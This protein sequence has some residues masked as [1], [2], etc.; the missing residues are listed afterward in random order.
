[1]WTFQALL[2]AVAAALGLTS[3]GLGLFVVGLAP[4]Q[5]RTGGP[6]QRGQKARKAT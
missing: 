6:H 5:R 2:G 3:L 1:M 4:R